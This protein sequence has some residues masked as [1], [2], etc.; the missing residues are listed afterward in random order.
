MRRFA[1]RGAPEGAAAAAI[2][3]IEADYTPARQAHR[4]GAAITI[5]LDRRQR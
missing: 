3:R 4:I 1:L 2:S 5:A